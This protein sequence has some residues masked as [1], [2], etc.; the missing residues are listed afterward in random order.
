MPLRPATKK[1]FI[2]IESKCLRGGIGGFATSAT[3]VLQMIVWVVPLCL[4]VLMAV[5][6]IVA[7][8]AGLFMYPYLMEEVTLWMQM[9][10]SNRDL[11]YLPLIQGDYIKIPQGPLK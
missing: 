4:R 9:L 2:L 8:I 3:P 6:L 7:L 10:K 11:M 1:R 5:I